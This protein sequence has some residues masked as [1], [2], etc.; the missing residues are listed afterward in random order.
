MMFTQRSD[1]DVF[2]DD[3]LVVLVSGQGHNMLARIFAHPGGEFGVH[4]GHAPGSFA[5]AFAIGILTHAFKDQTDA[6][7][8]SI[9]IYLGWLLSLF[10][11][12]YLCAHFSFNRRY[13]RVLTTI[14]CVS[15]S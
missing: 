8:H 3:H 13:R 14:V 2:D 1:A 4:L 11:V 7:S 15:I 10:N 12:A 9:E 5:Q 6:P